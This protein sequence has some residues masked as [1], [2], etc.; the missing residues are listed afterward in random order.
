MLREHAD[1]VANDAA[2]P[3][4][5]PAT[6]AQDRIIENQHQK[7]LTDRD[8]EELG[9]KR[10][11]VTLAER[12]DEAARTRAKVPAA[13]NDSSMA[14]KTAAIAAL[15]ATIAPAMH[16]FIWTLPMSFFPWSLSMGTGHYSA[17]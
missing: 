1:A 3:L 16:D 17:S 10:S 11:H 2:R 5:D 14:V 8:E 15:A 6:L 4:Y 12:R 13:P 7:D 9:L